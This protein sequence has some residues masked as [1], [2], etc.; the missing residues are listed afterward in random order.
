M[1]SWLSALP[2]NLLST[3]V[4]FEMFFI[5]VMGGSCQ[6]YSYSVYVIMP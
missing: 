3:R 6:G 5:C 1:L 2:V 4:L